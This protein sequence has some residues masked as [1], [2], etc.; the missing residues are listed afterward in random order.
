MNGNFVFWSK[1]PWSWFLRIQLTITQ[2]WLNNGL[3]PNRRQ[4]I[5]RT[6]A[7]PIHWRIYAALGEDELNQ[8][9]PWCAVSSTV[10]KCANYAFCDDAN[11][12][13]CT[14]M[15]WNTPI[16]SYFLS[17]VH[18]NP[19]RFLV[20]KLDKVC[21]MSQSRQSNYYQNRTN[22]APW[23]T[24]LISLPRWPLHMAIVYHS[25]HVNTLKH[26]DALPHRSSWATWY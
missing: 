14:F 12:F 8:Y 7:D 11:A 4:A 6:N 2:H 20:R 9:Q 21:D 13:V 3:V 26:F 24:L 5:I 1:F 10:T 15:A 18:T 19:R 22:T 17:V 25:L 16:Q 23:E